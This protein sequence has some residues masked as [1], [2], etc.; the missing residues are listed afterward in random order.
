M[1]ASPRVLQTLWLGKAAPE[2]SHIRPC[3]PRVGSF[4]PPP[5]SWCQSHEWSLS[6]R[7]HWQILCNNTENHILDVRHCH[8][9]VCVVS[10]MYNWPF[11]SLIAT[12]RYASPLKVNCK[13][14]LAL[15]QGIDPLYTSP[16]QPSPRRLS[17]ITWLAG[18]SH[19]SSFGESTRWWS[20]RR[21]MAEGFCP[22]MNIEVPSISLKSC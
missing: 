9:L 15:G 6:S 3:W 19:V 18:I 16:K 1:K 22:L 12:V 11:R 2:S 20:S 13:L 7:Y 21:L 17:M 14:A 8:K 10:C 4:P 5:S